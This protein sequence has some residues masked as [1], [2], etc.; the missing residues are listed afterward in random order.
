MCVKR[1]WDDQE[2][3]CLKGILLFWTECGA[4]TRIMSTYQKLV[5]KEEFCSDKFWIFAVFWLTCGGKKMLAL[6]LTV[7]A[8]GLQMLL[9]TVT[10]HLTRIVSSTCDPQR[11]VVVSRRSRPSWPGLPIYMVL[12]NRFL[13]DVLLMAGSN[14]HIPTARPRFLYISIVTFTLSD[15]G[16]LFC[17]LD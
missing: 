13:L 2:S 4:R 9:L 1:W 8:N 11:K 17:M 6:V 16:S 15:Y 5:P 12:W 7:T 10:W 14:L 3:K